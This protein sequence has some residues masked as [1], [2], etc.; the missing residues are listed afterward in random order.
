MWLV[1]EDDLSADQA[2]AL[3]QS[4]SKNRVIIGGPGSGKTLVLAHRCRRF[5]DDGLDDSDVRM[6]VYTNVLKDY[7]ASGLKSLELDDLC[8]TF[9][10]WCVAELKA[11]G[12]PVAS[13]R[14]SFAQR[15]QDL[16]EALERKGKPPRW[17]ALIVDEGQDLDED[18]LS[19]LRLSSRHVTLAMDAR[20]ELYDTG[21]SVAVACESLGVKQASA[22]LLSAYRCTP[23]IVQVAA[24]YL[25]TPTERE[26]FRNANLM[27]VSIQ[28]KPVLATFKNREDEWGALAEALSGRVMANQR[29]AVLVRT[30]DQVKEVVQE[31]AKRGHDLQTSK[32]GHHLDEDIPV[33]LTYHSAKGLTV[34]AVLLPLLGAVRMPADDDEAFKRLMFVGITRATHWVWL[35]TVTPVPDF[36][37]RLEGLINQGHLL[38]QESAAERQNRPTRGGTESTRGNASSDPEDELDDLL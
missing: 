5:I 15:R 19:I 24:E 28:E 27:A 25:P 31:M 36:L 14:N 7:I 1:P 20:Q 8:F 33:V 16:R 18:A 34:D 38:K 23:Y 4:A 11:L 37:D 26:Q 32:H 12:L 30:N 21:T 3:D 9:D 35:S 13:G 10:R 17:E 22:N 6:L 2:A 29:T